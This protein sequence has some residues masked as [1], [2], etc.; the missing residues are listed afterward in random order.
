MRV[1]A[2]IAALEDELSMLMDGGLGSLGQ[3][4][5]QDVAQMLASAGS[6]RVTLESG[7]RAASPYLFFAGSGHRLRD[8][9]NHII[10]HSTLLST[11]PD[12][13]AGEYFS[14]EQIEQMRAIHKRANR[15]PSMLDTLVL[16]AKLKTDRLES[17]PHSAFDLTSTIDDLTIK[18]QLAHLLPTHPY[19]PVIL[20]GEAYRFQMAAAMLWEGLRTLTEGEPQRVSVQAENASAH[21]E[22]VYVN[23]NQALWKVQQLSDEA[24]DVDVSELCHHECA[25]YTALQLLLR[26]PGA[27]CVAEQAEERALL[28][29]VRMVFPLEAQAGAR[30]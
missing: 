11:Y 5:H 24:W 13:Y 23:R 26:Y 30:A 28:F 14:Q 25:I 27:H 29:A 6:L 15:L 19:P 10:G 4:Q 3:K 20:N 9:L 21:V 8:T 7:Q 18:H 2:E 22:L 1:L 16:F 12:L 17:V